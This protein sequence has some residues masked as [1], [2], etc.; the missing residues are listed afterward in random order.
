MKKILCYIVILALL[1]AVPVER[2]DVGKLRPIQTVSLSQKGEL[3]ILRTD[4][5]DMGAGSTALQALNNLKATTSGIV[6]LDT[7]QFLLLAENAQAHAE[8]LREV[9]HD[10]V[11]LCIADDTIDPKAVTQYLAAH[12]M[13]PK[14]KHWQR[15]EE[16]PVLKQLGERLILENTE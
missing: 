8:E 4:T 16:L 12:N 6:Y 13:L 5:G 15:G 1:C 11:K 10:N 3:V 2:A 7:A 14:M 9:L